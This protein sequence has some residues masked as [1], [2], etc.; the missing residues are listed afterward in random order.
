[1]SIEPSSCRRQLVGIGRLLRRGR[2][3]IGRIGQPPEHLQIG[4]QRVHL[5]ELGDH[6]VETR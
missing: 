1:M 3:G 2:V 6:A 5:G 4:D